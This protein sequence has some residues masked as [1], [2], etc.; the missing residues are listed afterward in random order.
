[1]DLRSIIFKELSD[2]AIIK[3]YELDDIKIKQSSG[4]KKKRTNNKLKTTHKEDEENIF[5]ENWL[6]LEKILNNI[7]NVCCSNDC[8][9]KFDKEALMVFAHSLDKCTDDAQ[10]QLGLKRHAKNVRAHIRMLAS[11]AYW[12]QFENSPEFVILFI[13]GD[14]FLSAALNE[15]PD[16]IAHRS[17]S[18]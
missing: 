2:I 9:H 1:M 14:Q 12:S 11:K 13:P 4:V 7:D 17:P 5:S 8:F 6:R 18:R 10:R 15:E 16:L 3:F